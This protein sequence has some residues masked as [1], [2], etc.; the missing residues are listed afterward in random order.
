[1]ENQLQEE[2]KKK[3]AYYDI[4][5]NTRKLSH[6]GNLSKRLHTIQ[7]NLKKLKL[8]ISQEKKNSKFF[9]EKWGMTNLL[10]DTKILGTLSYQ[11]FNSADCNLFFKLKS[12]HLGQSWVVE[13][14]KK[15]YVI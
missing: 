6:T 8:F 9:F 12:P 11:P 4:T 2:I 13:L 1:M 7:L 3:K 5:L 14:E 15:K 10:N